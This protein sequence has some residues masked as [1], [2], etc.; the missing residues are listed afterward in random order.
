MHKHRRVLAGSAVVLMAGLVATACGGSD[1]NAA[2]SK[3]VRSVKKKAPVAVE[4]KRAPLTGLPDPS[5]RSATRAALVVKTGNNPEARPQVGLDVA[6]V[7][8]EEIVEGGI[9]R[10][11]AVYQSDAPAQ[12]GPVRSVRG[13]DPNLALS[14]GGIFAYS[15]GTPPNVSKIRSTRGVISVDE[16]QARGAMVRDSSGGRGAP[17]NLFVRTEEM[18]AKGGAPIPPHS[19]FEFLPSGKEFAGEP[20]ASVTVRFGGSFDTTYTYDAVTK[21]FLRTNAGKPFVAA[22]GAQ[23]APTNVIVQFI[24]YPRDSE[25]VT[26]GSGAAWAFSAGKLVRGTWQRPDPAVPPVFL[27]GDGKEILLTPGRTWV[28]LAKTQMRVDVVAAPPTQTTAK[29]QG[30]TT[31]KTVKR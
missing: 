9:T 8:F 7:V 29:S 16:T 10:F 17:N 28:E 15:G 6:D 12:V 31:P 20:V 22:S 19:L 14:V 4:A 27:D 24:Q 3:T 26:V 23:I 30:T 5:G 11:A 18:W 13:M 21:R 25:G 2:T 1:E